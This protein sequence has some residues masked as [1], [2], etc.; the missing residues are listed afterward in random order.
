[1]D[2]EATKTCRKCGEVKPLSRFYKQIGMK[3]G[4]RHE[5]KDCRAIRSSKNYQEHLDEKRRANRGAYKRNPEWYKEHQR[6]QVAHFPEKH[7]AR[8]ALNRAVMEGKVT[9]QPC[10]CGNPKAEAHHDDYSKPLEV[11]WLCRKHHQEAHGKPFYERA[12][13]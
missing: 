2:N 13:A 3:D 7:R 10:H 1:M 9:K 5:C 8:V 4:Y 11:R 6:K 12:I